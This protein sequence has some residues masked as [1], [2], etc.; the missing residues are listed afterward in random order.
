LIADNLPLGSNLPIF[1]NG[2]EIIASSWFNY[3]KSITHGTYMPKNEYDE[4]IHNEMNIIHKKLTSNAYKDRIINRISNCYQM[5]AN[6]RLQFFFDEINLAI[7]ENE[8]SA[9]KARNK[10]IHASSGGD[11]SELIKHTNVYKT[12]FNRVLLR[13]LE[14]DAKYID[15]STVGWPEVNIN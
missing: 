4:L 3:K 1:A 10:M 6:E 9:I 15:Y 14:Y 11:T 12:L 13:L 7:S 2:I 8:N 5:G